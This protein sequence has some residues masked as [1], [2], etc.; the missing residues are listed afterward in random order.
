ML[1]EASHEVNRHDMVGTG[2]PATL[3]LLYFVAVRAFYSNGRSRCD[4]TVP[5]MTSCGRAGVT[6]PS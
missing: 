6:A 2:C 1:V 4:V 5:C 3:A